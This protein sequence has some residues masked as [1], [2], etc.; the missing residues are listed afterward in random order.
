MSPL[1]GE[2]VDDPT[3][4]RRETQCLAISERMQSGP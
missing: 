3:K 4:F 2:K 1:A